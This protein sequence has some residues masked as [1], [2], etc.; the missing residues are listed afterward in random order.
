MLKVIFKLYLLFIISFANNLTSLELLQKPILD[1][2]H[3]P[4]KHKC[5]CAVC[6]YLCCC[7]KDKCSQNN[8]HG[9]LG[10]GYIGFGDNLILTLDDKGMF[11]IYNISQE[12]TCIEGCGM[13]D[14]IRIVKK[15]KAHDNVGE[16]FN[17]L[18]F[19]NETLI[20]TVNRTMKIWKVDLKRLK[21]IEEYNTECRFS[22]AGL[23]KKNDQEVEL[24]SND[25][26]ENSKIFNI[27][28]HKFSNSQEIEGHFS[29][30]NSVEPEPEILRDEK[31]VEEIKSQIVALEN[32][33]LSDIQEVEI[34]NV[35]NIRDE[36]YA[37]IVNHKNVRIWNL[38]N[39]TMLGAFKL[40]DTITNLIKV[41][42]DLI[43]ASSRS[44]LIIWNIDLNRNVLH[45]LDD[46]T[47]ISW[48]FIQD[49]LIV[50]KDEFFYV[51][52]P[53]ISEPSS[54]VIL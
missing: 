15:H 23:K 28:R 52:R 31:E 27:S 35:L 32:E 41:R 30:S 14:N 42:K 3:K 6:C 5:S 4:K 53:I 44:D 8:F 7:G 29:L 48:K 10:K 40:N 43:V 47:K 49:K 37:V 33:Y 38:A 50:P 19:D 24:I 1:F 25:E 54:C 9:S 16:N 45:L 18:M 26:N 2:S 39:K 13:Y 17:L 11:V 20:S 46:F 36:I 51:Y 34:N 21:F 22:I 12:Q